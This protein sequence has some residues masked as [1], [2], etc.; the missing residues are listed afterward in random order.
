MPKPNVW[1]TARDIVFRDLELQTSRR[2]T[3]VWRIGSCGGPPTSSSAR[4]DARRETMRTRHLSQHKGCYYLQLF[5]KPC[6]HSNRG[7]ESIVGSNGV[8]WSGVGWTGVEESRVEWSRVEWS[9]V[10][11]SGAE[12]RREQSR[13]EQSTVVIVQHKRIYCGIPCHKT[14]GMKPLSQRP[15]GW[16]SLSRSLF[17]TSTPSQRHVRVT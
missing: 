10:E 9:R 14:Y 1:T 12:Y 5:L 4:S 15:L 17:H 6:Q 16:R 7:Q 2:H 11:K 3:F 8:E 13:E